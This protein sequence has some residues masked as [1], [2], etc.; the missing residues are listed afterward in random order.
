MNL[1]V[2]ENDRPNVN[3]QALY[4][5]AYEKVLDG[6]RNNPSQDIKSAIKKLIFYGVQAVNGMEKPNV[7]DIELIE[8][9]FQFAD[10]VKDLMSTLTPGEFMNLFPVTKTYDGDR[11]EAKDYFSAMTYIKGLDQSEPIGAEIMDFLWEYHNPDT[12]MFLVHLMSFTSDLAQLKGMPSIAETRL[13]ENGIETYT[14]H[15][16]NEGKKFMIDSHGR[17]TRAKPSFPKYLR[18]V[19]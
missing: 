7:L 8:Y 12:R 11:W 13:A 19:Q 3:K 9:R 18:V 5:K 10:I 16:D 4:Y 6:Y 1:T 15:T 14:I 2:I 17:P